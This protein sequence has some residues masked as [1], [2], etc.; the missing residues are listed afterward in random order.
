MNVLNKADTLKKIAGL[1]TSSGTMKA[2]V[3]AALNGSLMHA[4]E[5]GDTSLLAKLVLAVSKPNATQLRKV[6]TDFA[7]L[8][9]HGKDSKFTKIKNGGMWRVS[10]VMDMDW[11]EYDAPK[12]VS[13]FD[14]DKVKARVL[15][16]LEREAINAAE[17]DSAELAN[18]LIEAFKALES[19]REALEV[20]A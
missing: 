5:H 6:I 9:W 7:P 10:D 20:A 18:D 11:T 4:A 19:V 15:A 12:K 3:Q 13:V 2:N 14:A 16:T 8:K 17:N 1:K